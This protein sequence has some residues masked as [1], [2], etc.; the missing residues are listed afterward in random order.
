LGSLYARRENFEAAEEHLMIALKVVSKNERKRLA[1][2]FENVGDGLMRSK[3]KKDA[4]R[5][6]RQALELDAEK[7]SLTSKLAAAEKR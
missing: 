1:Q 3:K 6:F 7:A 4:A 2:E 5:L